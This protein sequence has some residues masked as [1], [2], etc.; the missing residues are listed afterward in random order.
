MVLSLE[1]ILIFI[2]HGRFYFFD[3][4]TFDTY[5]ANTSSNSLVGI[6]IREGNRDIKGTF[7]TLLKGKSIYCPI[8]E[9][10]VYSQLDDNESAI[11]DLLLASGYLKVLGY[12]KPELLAFREEVQYELTLTN[13]EILRMFLTMVRGWFGP[14]KEIITIL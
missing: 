12:D 2:S 5:W 8:D 14:S 1:R 13:N 3:E 10:I 11:W 6:L 7:E 4:G 9:Q